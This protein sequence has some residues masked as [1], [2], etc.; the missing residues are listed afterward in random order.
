MTENQKKS[1]VPTVT[2]MMESFKGKMPIT[3]P[4]PGIGHPLNMTKARSTEPYSP[5]KVRG[6]SK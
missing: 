4:D 3:I 5:I 2:E 1:V 6:S